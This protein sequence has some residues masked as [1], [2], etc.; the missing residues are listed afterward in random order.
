VGILII[1]LYY[2]QLTL[3]SRIRKI[4]V[5]VLLIGVYKNKRFLKFE[6]IEIQILNSK[7]KNLVRSSAI[8]AISLSFEIG[9]SKLGSGS[10][11]VLMVK[12]GAPISP[13]QALS[14]QEA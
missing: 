5:L 9:K 7:N 1:P 4:Q 6:K 14:I 13:S 3:I 11:H 8:V 12:R 2:T 10:R